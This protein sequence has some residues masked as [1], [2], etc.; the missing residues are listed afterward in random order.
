MVTESEKPTRR[1]A[2]ATSEAI[3]QAAAELFSARGY[4]AASTRDIA[5]KAGVNVALINRYFGSKARLF[6]AAIVPMLTIHGMVEGKMDGFGE[7]VAAYYFGPLPDK[8][9]DPILAVLRSTGSTEIADSLRETLRTKFV[10]ELAARLD[11]PDATARAAMIIMQ[12]AG[13]DVMV[14]V[15]R[16]LPGD[17]GERELIRERFAKAI[18]RIVDEQLV[19]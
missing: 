19:T 8:T 12:I 1:G 9:A 14:R 7:R 15:L 6:D 16:V 17:E 13:V 2:K 5:E 18:Q 3:V 11:G 10:D 4:D